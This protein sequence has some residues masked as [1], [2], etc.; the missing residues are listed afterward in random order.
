[1]QVVQPDI[2]PL[3]VNGV[4]LYCLW[5]SWYFSALCSS[6]SPSVFISVLCFDTPVYLQ[7]SSAAACGRTMPAPQ[8]SWSGSSGW[9]S[10]HVWRS[11]ICSEENHCLYELCDY[12]VRGITWLLF[13]TFEN[14]WNFISLCGSS[15]QALQIFGESSMCILW[16]QVPFPFMWW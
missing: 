4:H 16:K 10:F 7:K 3:C 5:T 14:L 2:W 1:M 9:N 11:E 6:P 12:W 8:H 13:P 15:T